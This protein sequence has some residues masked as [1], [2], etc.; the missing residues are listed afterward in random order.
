MIR[1]FTDNPR[2]PGKR[3]SIS[4]GGAQELPKTGSH[5]CICPDSL[6]VGLELAFETKLL[7]RLCEDEEKARQDLGEEVAEKLRSRLADLRAADTVS[8]LVAG[9]P[10][11]LG[12]NGRCTVAVDLYGGFQ[13][14]FCANHNEPPILPTGTVDWTRTTRIKIIEI[15]SS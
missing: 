8:A 5:Y 12:R 1:H 15:G 13:I 9:R 2:S 10:R 7:R 6:Q 4:Y 14:I 11:E 3:R